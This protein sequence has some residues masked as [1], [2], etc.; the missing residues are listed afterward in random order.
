MNIRDL[1]LIE[2]ELHEYCNRKCKWCPNSFIDRIGHT[3]LDK[4]IYIN[5]IKELKDNNYIGAISYSRYNE[6]LAEIDMLKEYTKLTKELL[7][8]VK[9]VSNTNGDYIS[10]ENL[11]GLY[12][13]ELT[14]MDYD[15]K[16]MYKCI[17]NLEDAGVT[18]DNIEGHYINGHFNNI[19]IMYFVEWPTYGY[20]G[21][22]GGSL[23]NYFREARTEP[24]NEP[25]YFVGVDFN[26]A[27]TP[28]CEV[29]S[30]NITHQ[31]MIQG[32]LLEDNSITLNDILN[33]D[34]AISIRNRISNLEFKNTPCE[35][36]LKQPGRYTKDNASIKY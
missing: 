9:L 11:E 35:F 19:K 12:I 32:Y 7:P 8:N 15:N 16:G 36:C 17:K 2:I 18:I 1:R 28:C 29:R 23:G 13:D 20:I 27:I 14:I 25:K 21:N 10:K 26:G 22:R 34:K 4:N 3:K 30:D 31:S 5:L 33:S 24:C 6:P